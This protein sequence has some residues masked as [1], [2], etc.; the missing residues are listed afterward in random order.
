MGALAERFPVA[1]EIQPEQLGELRTLSDIAGFLGGA[2]ADAAPAPTA[3][4][5]APVRIDYPTAP[6]IG[7]SFATLRELP[8]PDTLVDAYRTRRA[9]LLVDDGSTPARPLVA[10]LKSAGWQTHVLVLPGAFSA[11]GQADSVRTLRS[12]E[13]AELARVVAEVRAAAGQL[14]LVVQ[15]AAATS[16]A[17]DDAGRRLTHAL[18]LAKETRSTL[19]GQSASGRS[20]F[21]AVTQLDGASG[22]R[23]VSG[24]SAL[25]GGLG[26]L[27]KTLAI[28]EPELF[29]R[30][31]D[32]APGLDEA[33][34]GR[35][36]LAELTDPAA[37]PIEVGH[38][39]AG[40]R[41]VTLSV[42]PPPVAPTG[43]PALTAADVLVVTGGAR[44]ITADCLHKLVSAW[45]AGLL[46]LGRSELAEEPAW[47]RG[48]DAAPLKLAIVQQLTAQGEKPRPRDVE[49]I[50]RGITGSR[51]IAT[52]L[53]RLRSAGATVEYLVADIADREAVRRVLVPHRDRITGV[54]HGA[55]VLADRLIADKS[56]A[57]VERVLATKLTG[58]G[59]LLEVLDGVALRHLVL[60]SSVAGFF[61]NRGQADYAM[62]NDA[63]N[64]LAVSLKKQS[65]QTR[66]S[67]INWGAWDGGMVTDELRAMFASR[68]VDLVPLATGTGIFAEQFTAEH[69][70]DVVIVAGPTGPLSAPAPMANSSAVVDR[71][72]TGLVAEPMLADHRVGGSA[73]LPATMALGAVL[74]VVEATTGTAVTQVRS[75]K[76]FKGVV[77]G[78][79]GPA[80]LRLAVGTGPKSAAGEL[81][82]LV[83]AVDE[84]G[85]SRPAYGATVADGATTAPADRGDLAAA[86]RATTGTD[87]AH[88]YQDGTLFHG[89]ALQGL[90]RVLDSSPERLLLAASLPASDSAKGAYGSAVHHPA[91]ADLLLQAGLVWVR[92]FRGTASLP[93]EI[94]RIT[95][96]APL[97]ADQE[98]LI[99]VE[100][101]IPG[102]SGVVATVTA[103]TLDG[104]VLQVLEGVALIEDPELDGKFRQSSRLGALAV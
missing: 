100:N 83:S 69:A 17:W 72:L 19:T 81:D 88:L 5:A 52:N 96:H 103:T 60:F 28:E 70:D 91:Q 99:A 7:R 90:R 37:S 68:G 92:L 57:D 84:A 75:F 63:L 11:V 54:V 35:R 104:R 93:L 8:A 23:G 53:E 18:L 38:D 49:A 31:V 61:G 42:T 59:N 98:F 97:P 51:E 33:V 78:D 64:R 32:F 50:F 39:A 56:A 12:W 22:Y 41:T 21:V 80:R 6:G 36:F 85:T 89:P 86:A 65:P 77:L 47:A 9:A 45:P 3:V 44:G 82:V 26:G 34:L 76:V 14:D 15:L 79:Q 62:A 74:N 24:P 46:L 95:L 43:T 25:L 102:N 87:A 16:A 27:V 20:A 30:V 13:P 4:A 101:V 73:V 10:A 48:L 29:C 71:S 58:L 67:S 55:G 1:T 40:R 66:V 2:A 94:E